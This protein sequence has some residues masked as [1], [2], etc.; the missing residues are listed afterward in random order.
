[1]IFFDELGINTSIE[2]G[3]PLMWAICEHL[4]GLP[5][6]GVVVATHNKFL[7]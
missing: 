4:L 5:H 7:N 1:M 2:Q 3:I 6:T